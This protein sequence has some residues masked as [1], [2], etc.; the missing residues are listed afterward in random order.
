MSI[1][2][3]QKGKVG[4]YLKKK[5][6]FKAK[7]GVG[8]KDFIYICSHCRGVRIVYELRLY[9]LNLICVIAA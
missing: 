2:K 6:D 5:K 1:Q 7:Q 9:P 4:R 3:Q 8:F